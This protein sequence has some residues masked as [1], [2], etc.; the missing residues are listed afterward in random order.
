MTDFDEQEESADERGGPHEVVG[1]AGNADRTGAGADSGAPADREAAAGDGRARE[2]AAFDRFMDGLPTGGDADLGG[3]HRT[4]SWPVRGVVELELSVDVGRIDVQLHRADEPEVRV[5]V[6]HDPSAGGVWAQGL[7][8]VI[9]WLG[10][11]TGGPGVESADLA[12][13][14]VQAAEVSW[15]EPGRRLV[16][17]SS[18]DLPHR[19]VPLVV[20]VVAPA[21]SRL[22]ARTG[23]GDVAVAGR[24][25]WVAVRTGSGAVDVAAVDGD[26]DVSTGSGNVQLGEVTGRAR[27]RTG[28]GTVQLVSAGGPTDIKAS[29]GAITLGRV[30]AD[31]GVSTG[32]G[33]V[34]I[35][36]AQAGL[37][38]LTT[39]S[40]EVRVAVHPGVRA[41]LDLQ[42]SSGQAR[43]DL[44]VAATQPAG[45]VALRVR[46]RTGSGNVL[47]TRAALPA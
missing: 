16:V 32:S 14:A 28:S 11:A 39:G 40:G 6:R 2:A 20:T 34:R 8:G 4:L 46:G 38:D 23:A 26:T 47:V 35:D 17:R 9:N 15:S 22:A 36:D 1:S 5:E 30:V 41:E 33:E 43:S 31:L 7:S 24:A 27:L 12:A 44:A 37:L 29:S 45:S 21:G 18:S 3:P 19:V 13:E 10:Q 42:T 25:G